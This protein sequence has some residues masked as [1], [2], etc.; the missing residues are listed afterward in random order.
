VNCSRMKSIDRF[1]D[2]ESSL[3]ARESI[4]QKYLLLCWRLNIISYIFLLQS[5]SIIIRLI[6]F[7]TNLIMFSHLS[8]EECFEEFWNHFFQISD[9]DS[10]KSRMKSSSAA[11]FIHED[12]ESFAEMIK[13]L[14]FYEIWK[15]RS[16]ALNKETD[17]LY[18]LNRQQE[19]EIKELKTRL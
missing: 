18:E 10:L 14:M 15:A 11:S 6:L 1:N 7:Q 4:K 19:D 2:K 9:V 13:L 5:S 3:F 8:T 16:L 12:D 17:W